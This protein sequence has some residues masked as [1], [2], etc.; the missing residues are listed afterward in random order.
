LYYWSAESELDSVIDSQNSGVKYEYNAL[1]KPVI[2][3]RKSLGGSWSVDS[4]YIWDGDQLLMELDAS[5]NR[6]AD[7]AYYPGTIDQP[8]AE[9]LGAT[10]VTGYRDHQM[11]GEG[12]V[13]GTVA[14]TSVSQ[15]VSYDP[16]GTPTISGNADNRLFWKGLLWEGDLVSLYYMRNRWYDPELGRF[17]SEDPIGHA[18]GE[19]LYTFANNDPVNGSDP[20]GL[21]MRCTT[22]SGQYMTGDIHRYSVHTYDFELCVEDGGADGSDDGFDWSGRVWGGSAGDGFGPGGGGGPSAVSVSGD[23]DEGKR[24]VSACRNSIL[25]ATGVAVLE[26]SGGRALSAVSKEAWRLRGVARFSE[27]FSYSIPDVIKIGNRASY[28]TALNRIGREFVSGYGLTSA[29]SFAAESLSGLS[30]EILGYLPVP[31][32]AT[33]SAVISAGK[34]CFAP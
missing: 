17:A 8:A 9:E 2:K 10:S 16:W 32:A 23:D 21:T 18:G 13:I 31:G 3:S 19:N 29:F 4:Y 14:G 25:T 7:Y 12:N 15:Q 34:T 11:D 5:G 28:S 1:G 20:S 24:A 22:A 33:V 6:R 30:H 26:I 27:T